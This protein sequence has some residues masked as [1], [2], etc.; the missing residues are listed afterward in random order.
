MGS[1]TLIVTE[2]T[3]RVGYGREHKQYINQKSL[4]FI[5]ISKGHLQIH[6][7]Q[8]T[9]TATQVHKWTMV[10]EKSSDTRNPCTEERGFA[11][12]DGWK[13]RT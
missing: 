12:T 1:S 2:Q 13:T 4:A 8:I 10:C 6:K 7:S 11:A 9:H 5:G 3:N